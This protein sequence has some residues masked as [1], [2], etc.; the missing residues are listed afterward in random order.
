ML[1][2]LGVSDIEWYSL[3]NPSLNENEWV[4]SLDCCVVVLG[5]CIYECNI[6]E[7]DG[8]DDANAL[9]VIDVEVAPGL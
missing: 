2:F 8:E 1:V 5:F 4:D 7:A 3:K 6:D 9:F